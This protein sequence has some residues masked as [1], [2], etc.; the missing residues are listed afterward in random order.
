MVTATFVLAEQA[1]TSDFKLPSAQAAKHKYDAALRKADEEHVRQI[2]DAKK[3]FL[4]DL[5]AALKEATRAVNLPEANK[6]DQAIKQLKS[7]EYP[8]Q[9]KAAGAI[10]GIWEITYTSGVVRVYDLTS[11]KDIRWKENGRI[12]GKGR[13]LKDNGDIVIDLHDGKRDRITFAGERLFV[14]H[15]NPAAEYPNGRAA[16]MGVG[17]SIDSF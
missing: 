16:A 6:I 17:Q 8:P 10:S 1:A 14:E 4:D 5:D 15:F 3:V 13:L 11:E 7:G 2:K 9:R 12:M